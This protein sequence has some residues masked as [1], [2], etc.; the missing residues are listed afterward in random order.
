MMKIINL[1]VCECMTSW[2]HS[3]LATSLAIQAG[4]ISSTQVSAGVADRSGLALGALPSTGV[5][6]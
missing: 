4:F 1:I 6:K 3:R 5:Y 2:K